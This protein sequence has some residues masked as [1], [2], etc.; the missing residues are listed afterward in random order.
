MSRLLARFAEDAAMYFSILADALLW[1]HGMYLAYV[2]LGQVSIWWG[3]VRRRWWWNWTRNPWFRWTHLTLILIVGVEAT[4]NVEC[5]LTRWERGC[6]TLAGQPVSDGSFLGQLFHDLF[7]VDWSLSALNG[8][9]IGF[10]LAAVITF[11]LSPP[12]RRRSSPLG[13]NPVPQDRI[14]D[15]A[16]K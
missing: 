2:V 8:L 15:P 6:R 5:P 4:F 16:R 10:A 9:Q 12:R 1:I 13:I 3:M 11:V 14:I 7:S